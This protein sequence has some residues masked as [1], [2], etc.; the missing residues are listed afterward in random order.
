MSKSQDDRTRHI[1]AY[2]T[3]GR[4]RYNITCRLKNGLRGLFGCNQARFF[5]DTR[6]EADGWLAAFFK[7]SGEDR[8]CSI[9]G[10]QA[11]GTFRVDAFDCYE[12]GDAKGIYVDEEEGSSN[13]PA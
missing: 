8:L 4:T 9:A 6:E 12:N 10:E 2:E 1:A 11:R 3:K 5:H 13:A 7:N